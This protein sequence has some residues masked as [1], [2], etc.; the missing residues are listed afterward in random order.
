MTPSALP[1]CPPSTPNPLHARF[2]AILPRIERHG[3]VYFRHVKCPHRKEEL[4]AEM[5][6]LCWKWFVRLDRRGK[7]VL[8]FVSALATYAAR[9]ANSGRRVCGH[10]RAKDALSPLARRKHGFAVQALPDYSPLS[11]NPL[12]EALTDNTASPVPEQAAFRLD[13][14][15]WRLAHCERDRRLIDLLLLGERTKDVSREF[16]LSQGRISQK[17]RALHDDWR[18]FH[19]EPG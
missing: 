13:F 2:L 4:L 6:A 15:A 11:G 8:G 9:A 19:G 1:C 7:D 16:G 14:P 18:R 3:E 12:E 10:E 5:Y 17:R